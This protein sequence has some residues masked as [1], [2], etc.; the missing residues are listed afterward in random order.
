MLDNGDFHNSGLDIGQKLRDIDYAKR[1]LQ[2][3][4]MKELQL[5]LSTYE[6]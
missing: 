3:K 1:K 5:V 2:E 4:T 6:K